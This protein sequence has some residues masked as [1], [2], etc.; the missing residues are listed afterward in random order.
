M[1]PRFVIV[2]LLVL[3]LAIPAQML[4]QQSKAA[5]EKEVRAVIDELTKAN[6]KG[7]PEVVP[8]FE[9]YLADDF[10]RIPGNGAVFTKADM[11][12]GWKTGR[13]KVEK[14]ELSDLKIHIYGNTAVATG[15]F[16]TVST[17][18][19]TNYDSTNRWTRV[20]VKRDGIW[21]NVLYQNTPIKQ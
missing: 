1:K 20:F 9:K 19:G 13:I 14:L 3:A 15:I 11:I 16:K 7:G 10:V 12:D 5:K 6:L 21:K 17:V 2:M 18:I 8:I 4:A